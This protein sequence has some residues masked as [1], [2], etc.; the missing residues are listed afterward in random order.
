MA[1]P[2]TP[3][4]FLLLLGTVKKCCLPDGGAR[5]VQQLEELEERLSC[6]DLA[7]AGQEAGSP[8]TLRERRDAEPAAHPTAAEASRPTNAPSGE[9][10]PQKAGT[11]GV[12]LTSPLPLAKETKN[13]KAGGQAT[14][15]TRGRPSPPPSSPHLRAFLE[16]LESC[17]GEDEESGQPRGVLTP[18]MPHQKQALSWMLWRET[19]DPRGGILADAMG[20]GKTLTVLALI[21]KQL[22]ASSGDP[23]GGGTLVVCPVSLVHQWAGEAKR[24]LAPPLR[25]HVHHGKGRASHAS[26]LARHRLVVTSYETVSSE[27][28][29]WRQASETADGPVKPGAS[30]RGP[31]ALFGVSWQ[32][33]VLDEAHVV[34]N[35]R[36]RRAKAV[37]ALSSHARWAVTGTPVHND[38]GDLRSLLKFLRCRPFDD[39]GFWSRWSRDHPGPDSMAVVVKCLLLRRTKDQKGKDNQP[40]VPLPERTVV[41]HKL[42]LAGTEARLYEDIDRWSRLTEP[43]K[44][45]DPVSKKELYRNVGSRRFVALIRLQQACSHPALLK[46]RV[47]EDAE[48]D[49]DDLLAACFSGLSLNKTADQ[50]LDVLDKYSRC[51]EMER[52]FTSCKLATLLQLLEE[53]P[54]KDKSVVLS[55]WTSLLAL[56]EEHLGRRA[57]P[58]ATIQ[59]SV[60][61][62]RRAEIVHSFNRDPRGPKVLLLSL[63]AGG[64]GLNLIGANHMFALD[65][66]WNPAMEAQAFDRIHR[67]GQT[68]PV[69]INRLICA[70]TVEERILELQA[71][72]QRLADSVVA[73]RR[74]TKEDY[75]FL[76]PLASG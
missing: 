52:S 18:L 66:H 44:Y 8:E 3:R 36:T 1:S 54:P 21:Q 16:S 47:L 57:I 9:V 17:P 50:G 12:L 35:L 31:A 25:A 14:L 58:C 20:L 45:V 32:R 68:K 51:S 56:V 64:V 49:C 69:V 19:Q 46:R 13:T 6:L 70:G 53:V 65:V 4:H 37:R 10:R 29:K 40:L 5:L 48:V 76:L 27:W 42:R 34:R 73:S 41:L 23:P 38:L 55:K 59:G 24:H 75:R 2:L 7:G 43:E 33:V 11:K 60:P 22:E 71:Q 63:E 61:G 28:D 26:E 74:L 62:Q 30:V 15:G 72:K 39:D 67:V